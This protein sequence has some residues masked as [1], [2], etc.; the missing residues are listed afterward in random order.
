M[1]EIRTSGLNRGLQ[2]TEPMRHCAW[3]PPMHRR[4]QF[5]LNRLLASI[6]AFGLAATAF[7]NGL[8]EARESKSGIPVL[9]G[10]MLSWLMAGAGIGFLINNRVV[11]AFLEAAAVFTLLSVIGCLLAR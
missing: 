3:G 4:F 8:T 11:V 9:I 6:S 10:W 7:A 2:E 1:Q 5:S